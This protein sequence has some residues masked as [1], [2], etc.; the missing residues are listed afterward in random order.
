[1]FN[2]YQKRSVHNEGKGTD[3]LQPWR[4][5]HDFVQQCTLKQIQTDHQAS[6]M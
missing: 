5:S 1:M 3:I 6:V 4:N 2:V